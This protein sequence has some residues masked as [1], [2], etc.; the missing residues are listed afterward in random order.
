MCEVTEMR[1]E[2]IR[3][4]DRA[5]MDILLKDRTTGKNI[6]WAT[7]DYRFWGDG[8]QA[9]DEITIMH[10]TGQY[11]EFIK[12]RIS[13]A[14]ESQFNRTRDMAEVFTPAWIC[15]AQNNLV[16]DSWFGR[17]EVFNVRQGTNWKTTEDPIAFPNEKKKDWKHYVDARRMEIACG[18]GPYLVSRYDSATGQPIPLKERI[19]ILDRKLRIVNENTLDETEWTAWVC[20]A[21]ESTYGYEFQGDSLL[22]ARKNLFYSY[23]EYYRARW[24]RDPDKRQMRRIATI[25]SW[26]LWQMYGTT[27]TIPF[28]TQEEEGDKQ[29]SIFDAISAKPDPVICKIKDWRSRT[30]FTFASMMKGAKA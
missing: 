16:D 7:D 20:R 12:P 17:K 15:N 8:F 5:V 26:N 10:I 4:L 24:Q 2:D 1:E 25:I 22:L 27:F 9:E 29:V 21:F 14:Q 28:H 13:K 18:E 23:L 6:I 19:G 3:A 11:S 30:I